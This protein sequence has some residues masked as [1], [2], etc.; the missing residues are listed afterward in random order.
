MFPH[1]N[2]WKRCSALPRVKKNKPI[3]PR[4]GRPIDWFERFKEG[5]RVY[6][7][8]VHYLG[9]QKTPEG[10]IRKKVEKCYLGPEDSY[11]YVSLTHEKDGLI[12]YGLDKRDRLLTYLEAIINSLGY[13]D[14]SGL[15]RDF[16]RQLS[17]RLRDLADV[18]EGL[19]DEGGE[20]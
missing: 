18:I 12:L 17:R 4:C 10:K 9:Y 6:L 2:I 5:N 15:S 11:R 8:A 16:L 13:L 19:I 1:I 7:Y 20:A 14:T 3:C